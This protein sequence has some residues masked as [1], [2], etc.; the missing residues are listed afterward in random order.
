MDST[1][2]NGRGNSE[3]MMSARLTGQQWSGMVLSTVRH[4]YIYMFL[5]VLMACASPEPP[6]CELPSS[7]RVAIPA[8]LCIAK[9]FTSV[10]ADPNTLAAAVADL[11]RLGAKTLRSDVLWHKVEPEPFTRRAFRRRAMRVRKSH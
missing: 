6:S 8:G 5:S 9:N 3:Q 1:T 10:S 2:R 4:S 7:D 11:Q